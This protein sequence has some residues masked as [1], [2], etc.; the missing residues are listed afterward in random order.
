MNTKVSEQFAK[1]LYHVLVGIKY[2][3]MHMESLNP[4]VVAQ[5]PNLKQQI[6]DMKWAANQFVDAMNRADADNAELMEDSTLEAMD[7]IIP[8]MEVIMTTPMQY[9]KQVAA[10]LMITAHKQLKH[11]ERSL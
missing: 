6:E 2:T 8:L 7:T 5:Y 4:K 1:K 3:E 10:S 9:R 11:I